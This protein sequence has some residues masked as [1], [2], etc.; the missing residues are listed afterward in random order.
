MKFN[1]GTLHDIGKIVLDGMFA[2]FYEPVLK[3][4]EERKISIYEAESS[5]LQCESR[6]S[7]EGIGRE[8]GDPAEAD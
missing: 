8:L 7:R 4:D 2:D 1:S 6:G 5:G 3:A